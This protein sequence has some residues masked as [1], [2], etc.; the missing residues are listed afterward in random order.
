MAL[1]ETASRPYDKETVM[2][3]CW[4]EGAGALILEEY[5]HAK[6]RRSKN[7]WGEIIGG[8]HELGC[9]SHLLP[10]HPEGAG[11]IK[12]MEYALEEAGYQTRTSRL[13]KH[14]ARHINSHWEML[15]KSQG[16][17]EGFL[18]IMLIS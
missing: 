5:E 12:V 9:I 17:S 8:G 3:L 10:P 4:G 11:I 15:V 2:V 13:Y 7:S 16:D 14:Y 6:R 1:P 18:A